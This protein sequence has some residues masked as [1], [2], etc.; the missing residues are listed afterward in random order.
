MTELLVEFL[1][2]TGYFNLQLDEIIMIIIACILLYLGIV[3]SYKNFQKY[4]F[5]FL[6]MIESKK[7]I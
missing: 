1:Q 2:S 4:F 5:I 6:K 7:I 3:K